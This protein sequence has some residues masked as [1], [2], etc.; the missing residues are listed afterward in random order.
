MKS[1]KFLI[2]STVWCFVT[3]VRENHQNN[4]ISLLLSL[5]MHSKYKHNKEECVY[6]QK[7]E[8]IQCE[9]IRKH[10]DQS[11]KFSIEKM[12]KNL[13]DN[14]DWS[15]KWWLI[16]MEHNL[17]IANTVLYHSFILGLFNV[18]W[19]RKEWLWVLPFEQRSINNG[20]S[21]SWFDLRKNREKKTKSLG[22]HFSNLYSLCDQ[23]MPN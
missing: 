3:L 17:S 6:S 23:T 2:A 15:M 12:V 4:R 1:V 11:I 8:A 7:N 14:D 18:E 20:N 19:W 21:C 13:N 22:H 16:L 5:W 9:Y 10:W